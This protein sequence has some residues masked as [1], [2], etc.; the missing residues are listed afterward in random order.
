M[1]ERDVTSNGTESYIKW[2]LSQLLFA[3]ETVLR[4][5]SEKKLQKLL[6]DFGGLCKRKNENEQRL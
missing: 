6:K 5:D 1:L 3:D 2:E 4:E